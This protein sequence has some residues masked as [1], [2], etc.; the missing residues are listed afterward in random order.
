MSNL[1]VVMNRVC[2]IFRRKALTPSRYLDEVGPKTAGSAHLGNFNVE[3]HANG[4]E[5]RQTRRKLVNGQT[6][7]NTCAV[8]MANG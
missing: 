3:R 8:I 5:E 7:F 6:G 2:L 4:P 1:R